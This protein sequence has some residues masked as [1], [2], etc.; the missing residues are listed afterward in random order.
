MGGESGPRNVSIIVHLEGGKVNCQF[1][2]YH[3]KRIGNTSKWVEER[4][5]KAT[6]KEEHD[7]TL[8]TLRGFD[9]GDP[10]L[11]GH[12]SPKLTKSLIQFIEKFDSLESK[13][14][15]SIS[16]EKSNHK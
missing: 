12:I 10:E 7:K 11:L 9:P 5:W 14:S 2:L 13:Y 8:G 1:I 3:C 16:S 15:L 4:K 6:V